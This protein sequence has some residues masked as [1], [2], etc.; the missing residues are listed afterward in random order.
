MTALET[1]PMAS[2]KARSRNTSARQA[3]TAGSRPAART[4]AQKSQAANGQGPAPQ[5]AKAQGQPQAAKPQAAGAQGT[6]Q[7]SR[8]K[9]QAAAAAVVPETAPSSVPPL[10]FQ[11]V[12]LLLAVLGLAVSAYETYAH[13][14][15]SNHLAGCP[16][17]KGTFNCFAVI[18]SSQSMVFGVFPVAVLGLI[19]Y[20]VVTALMTPWAW[21]TQRREVGLL[22]LVAMITGMGFVMYLIYAEV[23]QIGQICEYCTGVHIITFLLFCFTVVAAAIWGLAKPAKAA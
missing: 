9:R 6:A 20:V 11:L 7:A 14:S 18:T 1:N 12:T 23:V 10:W 15:G 8:A 16:I 17:G 2:S 13:F 5:A 19:F 22:R 21:R 4:S 3:R